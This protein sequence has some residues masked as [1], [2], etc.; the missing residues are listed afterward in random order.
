MRPGRRLRVRARQ[1]FSWPTL[2]NAAAWER[3]KEEGPRPAKRC[4]CRRG[5]AAQRIEEERGKAHGEARSMDAA[6]GHDL[7]L[8][9]GCIGKEL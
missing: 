4:G 8:L 6:R 9:I 1:V 2:S 7:L 5:E 3:A